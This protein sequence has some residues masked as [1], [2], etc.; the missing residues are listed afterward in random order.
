MTGNELMSGDTIDSNSS[1]IAQSLSKYGFDIHS[2]ITIGDDI[3]HIVNKLENLLL[4]S[5]II[6]IN[7]GLGPTNDDLTAQAVSILSGEPLVE[8]KKAHNH[9][10][11]W[12]EKKNIPLNKANYK[13]VLL[14]KN[15][16]IIDNPIGSAVGFY[17]KFQNGLIICTPGISSELKFMLDQSIP[18]I[19][20]NMFPEA[21]SKFILRLKCFGYGESSIQQLIDDRCPD[22]PE[23]VNLGF[24][25][26]IPLL[27]I[28]LSIDDKKFLSLRDQCENILRNLIGSYIIGENDI[29]LSALIVNLLKEK[30]KK[31]TLAESC[32]GGMIS[33]QITSIEGSSKIFEA[34]FVCYSDKMKENILSVPS[35]LILNHGAVSNE[36]VLAMA[37]GALFKSNA[38]YVIAVSGIAGPTGGSPDKPVG[39]VWIAWG[40]NKEL[41]SY[42][43][44]FPVERNMFQL[45]I[46]ALSQD[47]L[48]RF[49]NGDREVP[50]YYQRI[51]Q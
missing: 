16:K 47:L 41:L 1:L 15:S 34:G 6:I 13:Q 19:L 21:N 26:G 5:K 36:V 8:N 4:D 18:S 35:D 29:T 12:C 37:S 20:N 30:N 49:I 43:F 45:F 14:P 42:K 3:N 11:L 39:T 32:T 50:N 22:W 17:I 24:R 33:S 48:R 46:S 10:K 44:F 31:L 2:K 27:E 28:K 7:G 51:S 40:D 25:A 9:L 23:E 38:D